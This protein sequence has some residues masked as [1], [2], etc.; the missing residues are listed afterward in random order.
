[1]MMIIF[2]NFIGLKDWLPIIFSGIAILLS[3]AN[4]LEN[5]RNNKEIE[6]S[7]LWQ[8]EFEKYKEKVRQQEAQN[9]KI[10]KE[11]N[12]RAG[13]IPYFHL[14]LK[15][16]MISFEKNRVLI[17]INL[18]NI[19]KESAADISLQVQ[20]RKNGIAT[21]FKTENIA[22]RDYSIYQ[23]LSQYYALPKEKIYFTIVAE[24]T[25][26]EKL[27]DFL[28][29]KINYH[30]LLGNLYEQEF[31]FGYD[32]FELKGFNLNNSSFLPKVRNRVE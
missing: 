18:I 21:Y 6:K 27:F 20:E 7:R 1:M 14:S 4:T 22:K 12:T 11:L 17:T 25:E 24:T 2:D 29:F 3:I 16:S 23:Y 5:K 31:R 9:E 30:D 26:S 15:N 28:R 8:G 13:L 32:N 19:G 10:L